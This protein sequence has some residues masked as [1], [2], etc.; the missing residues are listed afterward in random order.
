[1]LDAKLRPLINPPLKKCAQHLVKLNLTANNLTTIGFIFALLTFAALAFQIYSFALIFILIN[2]FIDGLD[3]AVAHITETTDLGG[4]FDI[5]SDFV[6]YSGTIFFFA[7]GRPEVGLHAAFLIFTFMCTATTFLAYA[8]VA[9]KHG[10]NHEEQGEK[11]FFYAKGLAEGT[12]TIITFVLI[13][14]L[15][16]YFVFFAYTYGLMCLATALG[17]VMQASVDFK[18]K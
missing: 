13:C 10:I 5:V 9:A 11:T 2:R 3:G 7:V 18:D 14:L 15:P 12:E 17:R 16:D 1:M 6:F 4:Y 8:I